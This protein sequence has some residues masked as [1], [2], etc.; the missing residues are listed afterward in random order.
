[1][2]SYIYIPIMSPEMAALA[3]DWN[4]G[5]LQRQKAPYP[6]LG[7]ESSGVGKDLRRKFGGEFLSNVNAG[8]KVYILAHGIKTR[9]SGGA[10]WIGVKRGAQ[11]VQ[12][13]RSLTGYTVEGGAWKRY[14]ADQLA[15]HLDKEGLRH[16]FVDLRL[17]CCSAGLEANDGD[18]VAPY[19]ERLKAALTARGY[20]SIIVTGYT[21]D[22]CCQYGAYFIPHTIS[23]DSSTK[24]GT[25]KGVRLPGDSYV[26]R[27]KN[28]RV[29]F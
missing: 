12:S 5:R 10:L 3:A 18:S 1:M 22:L 4:N 25:G 26:S 20:N 21:G 8:D 9:T 29:Q 27:A 17:F 24:Q 2:A 23:A 19:A 7:A 6:I 11:Y 28:A 13:G 14:P 15:S 16:D